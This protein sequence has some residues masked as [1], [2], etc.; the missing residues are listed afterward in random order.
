MNDEKMEKD[1]K[2][3]RFDEKIALQNYHELNE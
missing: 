3:K 2:I 1:A